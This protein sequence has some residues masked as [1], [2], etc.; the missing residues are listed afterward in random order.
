M[1]YNNY[2]QRN[3]QNRYKSNSGDSRTSEVSMD[4]VIEEDCVM[5]ITI[6]MIIEERDNFR[7][8]QNYRSKN[9]RGGHRRNYR[10]DNLEELGI[11]LGTDNIQIISEGM[12]EVVV[13]LHQI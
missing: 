3:Y 1:L 13:G 5:S 2:Y 9:F 4:K 8:M 10:N 6:E 7:N 12:T 11:G